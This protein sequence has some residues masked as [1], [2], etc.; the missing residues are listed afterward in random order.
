MSLSGDPYR[1]AAVDAARTI[2]EYHEPR[3]FLCLV[4]SAEVARRLAAAWSESA[5]ALASAFWPGP[6]TLVVA[7]G[8]AAPAPVTDAGRL[9][10]R[11][12]SDPVSVALLGA[13]G[14]PVFSTS[15]NRRGAPPALSV[16]AAAEAL[17]DAPGGEAIAIGL[18]EPPS[19]AGAPAPAEEPSTIL[20]VATDP[21]RVVRIGAIG[22]ERVREIVEVA[23]E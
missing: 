16:S 22:L 23:G 7:A 4:A 13:W 10:L 9:A 2:K 6:L 20:D 17:A 11:P 3:P 15:A 21:P 14:K 8:D 5:E 12:A 1:A 19:S 18:L